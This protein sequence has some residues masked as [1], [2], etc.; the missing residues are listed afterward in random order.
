MF[1]RVLRRN[2]QEKTSKNPVTRRDT[3]KSKWYHGLKHPFFGSSNSVPPAPTFLPRAFPSSP[4]GLPASPS[5]PVRVASN[6]VPLQPCPL[7][8][9]PPAHPLSLLLPFLRCHLLRNPIK[10]TI[11]CHSLSLCPVFFFFKASFTV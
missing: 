2:K 10:T 8:K 11:L 9:D 3:V 5:M 4:A 6:S 7:P 1:I